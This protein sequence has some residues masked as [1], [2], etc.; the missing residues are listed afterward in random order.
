MSTHEIPVIRIDKVVKHPNADTLG[1]TEVFGWTCCVKLDDFKEGDLAVYIPPDYVVPKTTQFEFL[2]DHRRIR[3]KKLRGI[4][5]QGL[6]IKAPEGSKEGDDVMELL[7]IE[8]YEPPIQNSKI[9][10]GQAEGGNSLFSPKYDVESFQRYP[11]IL[12]EGEEVLVT[13]KIHGCLPA[14]TR[15]YMADGSK[16]K[17]I[18]VKKGDRVLGMKDGKII[19][20]EVLNKINNGR[21][22]NNR[23]LKLR[24]KRLGIGAGNSYFALICTDNHQVFNSDKKEF[25]EAKSFKLG[26][27]V[28]SYRHDIEITPFVEQVIIGK[29]L[30]DGYLH[31]S[32]NTAS[33]EYGH[34]NKEYLDWTTKALGEFGEASIKEHIGGFPGSSTIYS[35]HSIFSFLIKEKFEE[36]YKEKKV[37][38]DSIIQKLAPISLAF[39]YM[40]DG[41][42]GHQKDQED[43]AN[44]AVCA[45]SKEDCGKL[46]L[47]LKKF[48]INATYYVSD[49]YSRLRLNAEDAEKLFILITPY[50][51]KCMQYK[52]PERYRGFEAWIPKEDK[53]YKTFTVEQIINSIEDITDKVISL[54]YDLETETHN[55]IANGIVVHNSNARFTYHKDRM[56]CGSRTEWKK[57]DE[58]NLWW[59]CLSQNP[60]IGDFCK[61]NP[62]LILYGEVFGQVQD[63][64]Y[65]AK[66]NQYFFAAFDILEQDKW[67]EQEDVFKIMNIWYISHAPTIGIVKFNKELLL[68][69]AEKD[70][71]W[72]G[73]NHMREGVVIRTKPMRYDPKIGKVILKMVSNRYLMKGEK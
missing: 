61:G 16:K 68:K 20:T 6:I 42:L 63:L 13:E 27:K 48:D 10:G 67:W 32:A 21:I 1:I 11:N 56:W 33:I 8:R 4:I 38:P 45:F 70:S 54:K 69:E 24:G 40:D 30:G 59:K 64:K 17:I 36:F 41:S 71:L 44:F 65:G 7:G 28:L 52:L 12:Q 50:I 72:E 15:I 25:L 55:F 31:L 53:R 46:I 23:W 34:V 18:E 2:G 49:G 37:I 51:P 58:N 5:S 26:D 3:V 47:G 9:T 22:D 14:K 60:R 43:R 29:L 57:Y 39:W 35:S 19:E 66:Q 73:A 62:D